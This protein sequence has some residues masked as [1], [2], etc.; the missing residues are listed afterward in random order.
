MRRFTS[1]AGRARMSAVVSAFV[2]TGTLAGVALPAAGEAAKGAPA[3]AT[4]TATPHCTQH[5][6]G[7]VKAEWGPCVGVRAELSRAPA[8]GQ[9]AAMDVTVTS[10]V[11]SPKAT[12]QVD[13]SPGVTFVAAGG[14]TVAR[15]RASDGVSTVTRA[16]RR[17]ALQPQGT[18]HQRY[19]VHAAHA[20]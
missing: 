20:G 12:G 9:D 10:D 17:T 15:A 18:A 13:A 6:A 16:Q 8:L 14:A 5:A 3:P 11:A 19:V 1:R 2:V 7:A 4:A